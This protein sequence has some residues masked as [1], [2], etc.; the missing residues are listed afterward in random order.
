[1]ANHTALLGDYG[2]I[3]FNCTAVQQAEIV[4]KIR[5]FETGFVTEPVVLAP[6]NMPPT[7]SKS[8]GLLRH[9]HYQFDHIIVRVRNT[10]RMVASN[11]TFSARMSVLSRRF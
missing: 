6:T 4:R 5:R 11:P 10:Q 1:M 3:R 2:I 9:P 8:S 7:W